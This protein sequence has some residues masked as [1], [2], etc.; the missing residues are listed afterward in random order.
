MTTAGGCLVFCGLLPDPAPASNGK[1]FP[2]GTWRGNVPTFCHDLVRDRRTIPPVAPDRRVEVCIV[3]GGLAGLAAAYR[4][5]QAS[6][7]LLEHLDRIGGHAIRDRWNDIWFSGAAAYFT[8]VEPP[9]DQLYAELKLPLRKIQEP[10]DGAILNHHRVIDPFGSGL[11]RLPYPPSARKDFARAKKDFLEILHSDDC[12]VMPI[13]QATAT[14]RRYDR[15]SFAAWLLQEKRYHPA[16]KAYVDLYCR[17]AFGAPSSEEISAFAGISFY[18]SEFGDRYAFPGGNAQAAE[19]LRDAI[20]R[21]GQDRIVP[22]ATVV[23]VERKRDGVLVTYVDR[24]GRPAAVEA[25]AVVMAAPKYITRHLVQGLPQDQLEAMGELRYGSYLVG[26]VLCSAPITEA[27]YD[28]WTDTAPFTDFIVADW[29]TR[30]S[31]PSKAPS[32]RGAKRQVLTVYYPM[33]YQHD[34]LLADGAY[35][36]YRSRIVEHLEILYPGAA[37][38]IEEVYLYRWGHTLCHGRPGWYTRKAALASRPL[39]RIFFAH[40]DNQ[41]FPAFESALAEGIS[42]AEQA[43]SAIAGKRASRPVREIRSWAPGSIGMVT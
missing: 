2:S 43:A 8:S 35:N 37:S 10:V 19:F 30:G 22:G 3:G 29:V 28:T 18:A 33:G 27:A 25:R 20:D 11:P 38:K 17:S 32:D 31:A 12:P 15:V 39:E 1:P 7:L 9:L 41:G 21:A 4:L 5:R 36:R 40:S 16:V 26:N 13:H 14:A 6:I 24:D 23:R 34:L 42:T